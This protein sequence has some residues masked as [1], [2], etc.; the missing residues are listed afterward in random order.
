MLHIE[1][2]SGGSMKASTFTSLFFVILITFAL[3]SCASTPKETV[4]VFDPATLVG[5]KW[6]EINPY[7]GYTFT[8]EFEDNRICLWSF[9]GTLIRMEYMVRGTTII[10]ANR[11]SYIVDGDTLLEVK[12]FSKKP[13]FMKA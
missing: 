2:L 1:I 13:F 9:Q 5:T 10:L 8:L 6:V 12:G 4:P 11:T 7:P 3:F